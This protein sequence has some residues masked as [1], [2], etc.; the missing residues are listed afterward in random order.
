VP[1]YDAGMSE[2]KNKVLFG[3][4]AVTVRLKT[5]PKSIHEIHIDATPESITRPAV[6]RMLSNCDWSLTPDSR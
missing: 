2:S 4:H 5:H 3:F 1:G 6:A